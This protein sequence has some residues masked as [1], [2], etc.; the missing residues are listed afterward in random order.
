MYQAQIPTSPGIGALNTRKIA[1]PELN[2]LQPRFIT[3]DGTNATKAY[4]RQI[5]AILGDKKVRKLVIRNDSAVKV[6]WAKNTTA[7]ATAYHGILKASAVAKD[8]SGGEV[9]LSE[10]QPLFVSLFAAA[11]ATAVVD[12]MFDE[13]T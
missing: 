6:Y 13:A 7:S 8:G 3:L 2:Q 12:V 10:D 4:D 11:A 5:G 9:D 1:P